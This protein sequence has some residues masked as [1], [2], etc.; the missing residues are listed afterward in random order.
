MFEKFKNSKEVA[1]KLD[2]LV[3]PVPEESYAS[4]TTSSAADIQSWV[5]EG[6]LLCV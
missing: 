5:D 3:R 1:D 4:T 2:E 6:C